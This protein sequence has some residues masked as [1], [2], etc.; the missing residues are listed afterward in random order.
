MSGGA[1][2]IIATST[3]RNVWVR[4]DE[5]SIALVAAGA[6]PRRHGNKWTGVTR[7]RYP[8]PAL[9]LRHRVTDYEAWKTG[10]DEQHAT[11]RA[12]GCQRGRLLRSAAEPNELLILLEWDD[13]ERA[14]LFAQSDDLWDLMR[15]ADVMDEPDLWVLEEADRAA[16]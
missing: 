15:R 16:D 7:G 4:P 12:H 11:R 8:M 1:R 2:S 14:R 3:A 13:L 9:L 6:A 5:L 10:F